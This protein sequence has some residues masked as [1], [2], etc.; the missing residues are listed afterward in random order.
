MADTSNISKRTI[1]QRSLFRLAVYIVALLGFAYQSHY[2]CDYY[3][4]YPTTTYFSI[5]SL[6]VIE[7]PTVTIS[8]PHVARPGV[9]LKDLFQHLKSNVS[10]RSFLAK[11]HNGSDSN[12]KVTTS[13]HM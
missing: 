8:F 5:L 10:L 11:D 13:Y 3:F 2:I 1:L 12:L 4:R 7:P 6:D 9:V